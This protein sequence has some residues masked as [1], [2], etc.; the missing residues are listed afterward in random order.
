MSSS[1]PSAPGR[2]QPV[3]SPLPSA[4][5]FLVVTVDPGGEDAARE[6]LAGLAGR[7]RALAFPYPDGGLSCVAG[8]GADAWDR[9]FGAPRPAALYPFRELTGPRHKAVATPGDLLFHIRAARLDLCIA[10]T[11]EIMKGLRDAATVQDEV[12]AFAYYDSRNLLGFVDGTENPVGSDAAD[13]ALV[14]DED[15]GFRGGSYVVVQKYLHDMDAWEGLPVETQ[16]KIIGRTKATNV[17]L[18]APGSHKDVNSVMAP[19]GTELRILRAAMPFGRPGHGEFGTYFIA[20][21]RD[22]QVTETMLERMFLGTPT[23]GP[24]PLLDYS[25]AVTGTRFFVPSAD[26]LRAVPRGGSQSSPP[27]P[28]PSSPSSS[29]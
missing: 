24:D 6:V 3:L 9:L 12:H 25:R 29:A 2:P 8:V 23:S 27:S 4:A 1:V 17:E 22:P 16:E 19:D 11:A 10:L 13:A 26:F 20:Y 14:G 15:P 28:S 5:V 21:A 18:D 7:E